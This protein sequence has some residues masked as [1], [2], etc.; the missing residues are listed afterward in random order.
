MEL[1]ECPSIYEMLPNPTFNWR[2]QPQ[3]Q[4]WRSQSEGIETSAKLESYGPTESVI[5]FEEA[6]RH[7]EVPI[8]KFHN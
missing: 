3:I 6:L 5:L 1:V 8:L 2:Q 7:N 4:V